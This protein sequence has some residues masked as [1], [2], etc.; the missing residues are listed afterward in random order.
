M[1]DLT[2]KQCRFVDE[3][4]IDLNA[5]QA[6]VRAGYSAKT[7]EQ[8]GPRLL[9][10]V[11]V[12][13]AISEA[14]RARSTRTQIDQDRVVQEFARLGLS[15]MRAFAEWGPDGVTLK[16]SAELSDDAARCVAEVSE[17]RTKDGGSTVRF[18]IHPKLPALESLMK[19][20]LEADLDARL[21]AIEAKLGLACER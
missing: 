21:K 9:G 5:T 20:L 12:A 17:T 15:D 6:A 2:P 10:N 11:G 19:H 8:Q 3:Y 4:L 18:K 1:N 14:A 7:A 16:T 13:A